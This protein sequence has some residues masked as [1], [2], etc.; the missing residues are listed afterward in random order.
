MT[1]KM[2]E[3]L[4]NSTVTGDSTVTPPIYNEVVTQMSSL[5][6]TI[7]ADT[8]DNTWIKANDISKTN[9]VYTDF[10]NSIKERDAKYDE[11]IK[12]ALSFLYVKGYITKEEFDNRESSRLND[13]RTYDRVNG[14]ILV[15]LLFDE[16][17]WTISVDVG[18]A[19]NIISV[20]STIDGEDKELY[21]SLC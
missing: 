9:S 19:P 4:F 11:L 15:V 3:L 1:K 7:T 6:G 21:R 10:L 2:K 14:G 18:S 5:W 16:C 13:I 12:A 20:V 8:T 17:E